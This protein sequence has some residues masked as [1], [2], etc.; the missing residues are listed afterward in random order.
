MNKPRSL[1]TKTKLLCIVLIPFF[2]CSIALLSVSLQK[3]IT[4]EKIVT[5]TTVA[6]S[7]SVLLGEYDAL[8]QAGTLTLDEAQKRAAA[9]IK[10]LRDDTGRGFWL[11]DSRPVMIANAYRPDLDGTNLAGFQDARGMHMYEEA[12]RL[13]ARQGGGKMKYYI[14]KPGSEKPVKHY[15]YVQMFKPWGWIL[16]TDF[17]MDAAVSSVKVARA[18]TFILMALSVA[19]VIVVLQLLF[20]SMARPLRRT[21]GGLHVIGDQLDASS[22]QFA[23]A[24]QLLAKASSEQSAALE[25]T[26]SS[27]EEMA[28]TTRQNSGNAAQAD[29]LMDEAH[30]LIKQAQESMADLTRSM[31][32]ISRSSQETS[33]IIKTIDEIAFQTNLLALN[34][35][36][37]AARAGESGR[38]FAV[39]A[40]EV[41]GLA[42]RA[43]EA[44]QNTA[45][46]I[47]A[48]VDNVN[49]GSAL[50]DRTNEAFCNVAEKVSKAAEL[51]S[52]ISK[53]SHE[54]A[55]GI[56]QINMA[57]SEVDRMTQQNA[58]NAEQTASAAEELRGRAT[59]IRQYIDD[60][61]DLIDKTGKQAA[62]SAETGHDHPRLSA[63]SVDF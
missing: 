33:Q 42:M 61:Q 55:E 24:S 39:V 40:D 54:Q 16:G 7:A 46:L 35:A 3:S 10:N 60:L 50:T 59:E 45:S 31:G 8:V 22:R 41:R 34:A 19:L 27:M 6:N 38:G 63:G 23:Q 36:V 25:Q 11:I 53:A 48:T 32:G 14:N 5:S 47:E 44:A 37:E 57:V 9:A 18:V 49:D 2:I 29:S 12:L 20:Q 13:A 26:S 21:T 51:V 56:G 1:K 4:L 28:A 17:S 15:A 52:F 43:A 58:A 30:G 62:G